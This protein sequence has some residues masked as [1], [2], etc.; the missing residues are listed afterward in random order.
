MKIG[1]NNSLLASR[2]LA[3]TSQAIA[4]SLERLSTG[5]RINSPSD[6]VVDYTTSVRLDSQVRGLSQINL[7]LDRARGMIGVADS[8][9][10]SQLDLVQRM[11]EI[12]VEGAS[13]TLG[14]SAR[15]SLNSELSSLLEEFDRITKST[16]FD[17][18]KLLDGSSSVSELLLDET[19]STLD[20][21]TPDLQF[22]GGF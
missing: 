14:T 22:D 19:G 11:R 20:L 5:K 21:E 4:R 2:N 18:R 12:A 8:A 6:G 13:G 7:G 17:G 10:A 9:I 15:K 3:S 16:E 1:S